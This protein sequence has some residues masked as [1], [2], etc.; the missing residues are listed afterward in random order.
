MESNH[1][2]DGVKTA[3]GLAVAGH[4]GGRYT[5]PAISPER[6]KEIQ[7]LI[8]KKLMGKL[9]GKDETVSNS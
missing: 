4:H 7:R 5:P 8:I 2:S 6:D 3:P 9:K 1:I